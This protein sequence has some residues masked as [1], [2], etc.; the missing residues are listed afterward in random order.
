[1][2]EISIGKEDPKLREQKER[3]NFAGW[4]PKVNIALL[5]L[6]FCLG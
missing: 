2:N 1:M 4:Q 3:A 5:E 6:Q